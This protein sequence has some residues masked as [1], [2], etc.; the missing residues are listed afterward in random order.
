MADEKNWSQG[1][2]SYWLVGYRR[3]WQAVNTHAILEPPHRDH[4]DVRLKVSRG[5]RC[6]RAASED[7]RGTLID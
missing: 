7:S 3:E 2:M 5:G 1:A 4:H 6:S